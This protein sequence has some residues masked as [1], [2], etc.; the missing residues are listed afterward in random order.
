MSEVSEREFD[1][2]SRRVSEL[3]EQVVTIDQ[4]G[5]R[6]LGPLS[7]QIENLTNLFKSHED[8]HQDWQNQIRSMVIKIGVGVVLGILGIVAQWAHMLLAHP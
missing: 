7:Q 3:R 2:L 6:G 1:Q 5:T 4:Q 8:R